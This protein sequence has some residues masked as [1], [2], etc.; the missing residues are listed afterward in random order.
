M[1]M[2]NGANL[3]YIKDNKPIARKA[4]FAAVLVA[5]FALLIALLCYGS[6]PAVAAEGGCTVTIHVYDP[7]Q[8]YGKLAGWVWVGSDSAEWAMSKDAHTDEEFVK[9]GNAAHTIDITLNDA[10]AAKLKSGTRLGFLVV[11]KKADSGD[12]NAKYD[13][14]NLP[15]VMIDLSAAF[16]ENNHADVYFVRKDTEAYTDLEEAIMAFEKITS[17]KFSSKT[18]IYFEASSKLENNMD[19]VLYDGESEVT[20][21][22]TVVGDNKF[23]ASVEFKPFD[24]DFTADYRIQVGKFKRAAVSKSALIDDIDFIRIFECEDTQNLE[25]GAIVDKSKKETTFRV[26]AP[27]ANAVSL[28]L[29]E[30]GSEGDATGKLDLKRRLVAGKWGGVWERTFPYDYSGRYYTYSINNSGTETETIDPYAKACGANGDRGMVIDFEKANPDG[31]ENDKHIYDIDAVAADTPIVWE[32]HVRDFS[33]SPD[34]GMMY[35]GKYLAFTEE[36]T[37]VPGKSNLKTGINYL[38]DLGIT[39]VH[40]NPV[41]DFATIVEDDMSTADS[42]KDNF[43]WGYDPENYNIPE[44]SYS[45]DP[46][47]GEVRVNEF[48]QMVMALH[49]AGI[50]VIM[51]VVYNHTF[52]TQ[53]QALHNTVPYYYHRLNDA[54]GFADGTGCG[55]ETASERS[56]VRK[57][58]VESV[59]HW[60]DEYHIDGF[61]FD[62]MG[63]HDKITLAAVRDALDETDGGKGKAILMYGEPWA[64]FEYKTTATFPARLAVTQEKI[65]G[66]GKYTSNAGNKQMVFMY[67]DDQIAELPARVAIFNDSGRDSLRGN[68]W[69]GQPGQG[70]ANGSYGSAGGVKKMMEGGAGS[71]GSGKNLGLGSRNVAYAAA[72]DNYTL[73]DQLVGKKHGMETPLFYDDPVADRIKQCKLVSAA[74][75]MSSGIPFMLAGDEMGRTKYGNENSYKSPQKLNYINWSRQEAFADLYNHYK[76][77]IKARKDNS[78]TLFSYKRAA[79][80]PSNS[81]GNFTGSSDSIGRIVFNRGALSLDLNAST[82]SGTVTIDGRVIARI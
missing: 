46:S 13:K 60:A 51:D 10:T 73:W 67:Y 33:I 30:N 38:K 7:A 8:E 25:Y 36:N 20:A 82:L 3:Y 43:N 1:I 69:D 4:T 9:D 62:L 40:L 37:T 80:S 48:K 70:W 6:A 57:Y 42:T 14:E 17:A 41:Y 26:W 35:K 27:L 77:L 15:D 22:K 58:I 59:L 53:G 28:N 78:A 81:T 19:V 65:S 12:W 29:Y 34:S 71:E 21:G 16:D 47:R 45:T 68:L 64:G 39:Y 31:W 72:H 76:A 75:L 49:N 56:M 44:G 24:F 52:Q 74:Y 18:G 63:I 55:N 2:A 50:G 23:A 66:T 54:G 61:R 79:E 5:L 32:V 11:V